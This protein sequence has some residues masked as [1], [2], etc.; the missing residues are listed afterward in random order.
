M[1]E[2]YLFTGILVLPAFRRSVFLDMEGPAK[3]DV[4]ASCNKAG[5]WGL[6]GVNEGQNLSDG[7]CVGSDGE[8]WRELCQIYGEPSMPSQVQDLP[9]ETV[10]SVLEQKNPFS[11]SVATMRF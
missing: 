7:V 3:G 5:N 4:N 2:H 6:H 10:R 11:T 1:E 9:V 8:K